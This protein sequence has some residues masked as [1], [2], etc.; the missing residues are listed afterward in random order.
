[1]RSKLL[2]V[3][4]P[5]LIALLVVALSVLWRQQQREH[6]DAAQSEFAPPTA[7]PSTRKRAAR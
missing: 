2:W 4:L 7:P 6:D 5:G 1:M 3:F